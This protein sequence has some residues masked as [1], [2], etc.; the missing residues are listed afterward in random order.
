M[1]V[2]L[3]EQ[4]PLIVEQRDEGDR[5][6]VHDGLA[7]AL[8]AV[9]EAQPRVVDGE[10]RA[11]VDALVA[12]DLREFVAHAGTQPAACEGRSSVIAISLQPGN[13]GQR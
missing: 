10:E 3:D 7:I 6:G 8:G 9:G 5:T 12:Q 4:Q 1:A 13:L 11:L 2:L